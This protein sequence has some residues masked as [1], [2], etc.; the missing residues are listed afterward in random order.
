MIRHKTALLWQCENNQ[1]DSVKIIKL[2]KTI[3]TLVAAAVI[4]KCK[5]PPQGCLR[6]RRSALNETRSSSCPFYTMLTFFLF[7]LSLQGTLATAKNTTDLWTDTDQLDIYHDL[8]SCAQ[9]CVR[10]VNQ[11]IIVGDTY[12]QTYGCVCAENTKGLHFLYGLSNVTECARNACP[13]EEDV[14]AAEMAFQDICLVHAA[15]S[16]RPNKT[17]SQSSIIPIFS[18]SCIDDIPSRHERYPYHG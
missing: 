7:A 14:V 12:C 10:D 6:L 3:S 16:S 9:P 15:S 1:P 18:W 4:S 2:V 5:V 8:P 17:E 13:M 11:R